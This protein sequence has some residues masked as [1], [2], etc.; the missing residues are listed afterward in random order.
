MYCRDAENEVLANHGIRA[1]IRAHITPDPD[2]PAP[3]QDPPAMPPPGD[4]PPTEIPPV[5]EPTAPPPPIR[6][7]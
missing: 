6:A 2:T 1:R 7:D 5:S 3:E 4:V